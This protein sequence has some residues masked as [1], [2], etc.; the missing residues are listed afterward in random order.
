MKKTLKVAFIAAAL[1]GGV[2]AVCCRASCLHGSAGPSGRIQELCPPLRLC[3]GGG[4]HEARHHVVHAERRPVDEPFPRDPLVSAG[5]PGAHGSPDGRNPPQYE[6]G[7]YLV[8]Y[9]PRLC[10]RSCRDAGQRRVVRISRSGPGTADR[11]GRQGSGGLDREA[12]VVG[13]DGRH[14]RRLLSGLFAIFDGIQQAEGAQGDLPGDRGVRRLH[15]ALLSG[16]DPEP[17]AFRMSR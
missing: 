2:S 9:R 8:L 7:G 1:M 11:P 17:R 4:R 15:I 16:R 3:A 6:S 10:R 5:S 13:R 12:I 14:D